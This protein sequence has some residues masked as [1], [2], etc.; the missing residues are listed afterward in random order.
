MSLIFV[1]AGE[2]RGDFPLICSFIEIKISV[3]VR[4]AARGNA[5]RVLPPGGAAGNIGACTQAASP[6]AGMKHFIQCRWLGDAV[7]AATHAHSSQVH[8]FIF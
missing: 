2:E 7:T 6:R 4:E 3:G 8:F 5:G 1:F